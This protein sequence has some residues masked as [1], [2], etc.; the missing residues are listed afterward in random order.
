MPLSRLL[1]LEVILA[2]MNEL[3][4]C[5]A[6]T[7][8]EQDRDRKQEPAHDGKGENQQDKGSNRVDSDGDRAD[9]GVS[10][11]PDG[12]GSTALAVSPGNLQ[13]ISEY[14][15][16]ECNLLL[17]IDKSEATGQ[18]EALVIAKELET[19]SI[20][21]QHM[22][23]YPSIQQDA[24]LLRCS[25]SLLRNITDKGKSGDNVFKREEKASA[26]DNV[27]PHHPV[28]GLKKDLIRLIA[29]MAYK[30]RGNQDLVRSLD[31]IPLLLDLTMIDTRNPFITQW[32]VL[33]IRNLLENNRE[34]RDVLSGMSLQGMAGHMAQLRAMGVHTELRGGKIVVKP[35][36]K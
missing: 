14:V 29:N 30:H 34:N 12:N 36:D 25:V 27:D 35:V 17:E 23:L 4:A 2:E 19:L 21:A 10:A 16:R 5:A 8:Q 26:R 32:V 18:E 1:L 20:A 9:V 15:K 7:T 28:Y 31:G 22:D 33:A 6:H 24:D 3:P 13:F 11:G